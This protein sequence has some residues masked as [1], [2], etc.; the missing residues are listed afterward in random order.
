MDVKTE[1]IKNI[2]NLFNKKNYVYLVLTTSIPNYNGKIVI[3]NRIYNG[4]IATPPNN[5][6]FIPLIKYII[7]K[8]KT[9]FV[10][11]EFV[12][13]FTDIIRKKM[14]NSIKLGLTKLKDYNYY[15]YEEKCNKNKKNCNNELNKYK[16]CC[17]IYDNNKRILKTR[18][19]DYGKTW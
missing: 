17:N 7:K 15:L 10:Y 13:H 19:N 12:W 4:I 6:I 3:K 9:K 8:S 2:D 11:L 14:N 18:F 1:L 5:K 16:L